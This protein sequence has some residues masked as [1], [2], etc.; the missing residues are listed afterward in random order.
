[1]IPIIIHFINRMR[2]RR[3]KFAAMEFLLAS[4]KRNRRRLL[5]EQLLLLLLRVLVVMAV[6]FLISR[7]I[8]NAAQMAFFQGQKTHHVVLLDDSASQQE[9]QGE[10]SAFQHGI[11]VLTRI[12]GEGARQPGTQTLTLLQLSN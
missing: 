9:I 2:F 6:V 5:L 7:P 11:E 4:Q 8:L 12:V 10:K 3:V 1:S